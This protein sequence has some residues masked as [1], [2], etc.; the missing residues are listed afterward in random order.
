VSLGLLGGLG[1]SSC[2]RSRRVEV[3]RR[4]VAVAVAVVVAAAAAIAVAVGVSSNAWLGSGCG[5]LVTIVRRVRTRF[6]FSSLRRA[7]SAGV[8]S[9]RGLDI[10][11]SKLID[12]NSPLPSIASG[13]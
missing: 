13:G 6:G 11:F 12:P 1:G 9:Y 4:A 5:P 8:S 3:S 10:S 2:E 7:I